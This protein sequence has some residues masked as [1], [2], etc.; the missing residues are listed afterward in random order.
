MSSLNE[1]VARACGWEPSGGIQ[2]RTFAHSDTGEPMSDVGPIPP[3]DY[4]NDPRLWAGELLP[5]LL[6]AGHGLHADEHG[7]YVSHPTTSRAEM[8]RGAAEMGAAV[9]LAYLEVFGNE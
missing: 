7:F 2:I 5:K 3:P 8:W 6:E 9:C 1:R 4:E